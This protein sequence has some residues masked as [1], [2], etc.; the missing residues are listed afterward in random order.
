MSVVNTQMK[1]V[2]AQ[3]KTDEAQMKADNIWKDF[4]RRKMK[5]T[6]ADLIL[7]ASFPKIAPGLDIVEVS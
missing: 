7:L 5:L 2:N 6:I 3:T 1:V 4:A